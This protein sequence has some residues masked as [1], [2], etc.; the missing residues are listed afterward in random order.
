MA[1]DRSPG[2]GEGRG[3]HRKVTGGVLSDFFQKSESNSSNRR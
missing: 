3:C 1:C 2:K